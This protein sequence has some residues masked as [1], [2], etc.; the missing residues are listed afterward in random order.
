MGAYNAQKLLN[1]DNSKL[2][3]TLQV[4][5]IYRTPI[6]KIGNRSPGS[7]HVTVSVWQ[8]D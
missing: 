4:S 3:A 2:Y 8:P 5:S 6:L 1:F 7:V